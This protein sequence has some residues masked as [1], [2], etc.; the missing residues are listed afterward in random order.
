[1]LLAD[2][3]R[4]AWRYK[5]LWMVLG[6]LL[7]LGVGYGCAPW[8]PIIKKLWTATYVC[9]AGGWSL[10]FCSGIYCL[11][12]CLRLHRWFAP[13]TLF[14]TGALACYL[15]PK[16]FD[17]YGASWR[18]LGGVTQVLTENVA[19]H[20][21]VCASGALVLLWFSVWVL[22]QAFRK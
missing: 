7:L 5:A 14:G 4:S 19:L 13:I 11:T 9:V 15:L 2:L 18:L 21:A 3:L 8:V 16:V 6:G 12:D 22:R 17:V 10:L 20:R 1:M